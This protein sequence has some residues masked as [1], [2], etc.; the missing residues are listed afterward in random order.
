MTA[1]GYVIAV[2]R[3]RRPVRPGG[4]HRAADRSRP[5]GRPPRRH[6]PHRAAALVV[7]VRR[8]APVEPGRRAG[9]E[10]AGPRAAARRVAPPRRGGG[11]RR[12][13][14]SP[15]WSAGAGWRQAW[16]PPSWSSPWWSRSSG[17]APPPRARSGA[18]RS[19]RA[20]VPRGPAR[21]TP[22]S[23]RCSSATSRPASSS[24]RPSTSSC[25]PRTS[26]TSTSW[27]RSDEG[28]ELADLARSARHDARRRRRR[29]RRCRP[30]HQLLGRLRT[31]T[32]RSSIATTRSTVCRSASTSRCAWLL[33]P[34]GGANLTSRDARD[35]RATRAALDPGRRPQRGHLVGD[36]LRRP[37]P[38]RRRGRRRA[39]AQPDE[40]IVV[41]RHAGAD[42]A[43][44]GVA[45]AGDRE[46]PVA[47]PGG[48]HRLLGDHR[49][50]R[51]GRAAHRG[52]RAGG[53]AR[54]GRAALGHDAVHAARLRA[55][56]GRGAGQ[57]GARVAR[58]PGAARSLRTPRGRRPQRRRAHGRSRRRCARRR[59]A[60]RQT[61]SDERDGAVVDEGDAHVGP[62]APG[63]HLSP[64]AS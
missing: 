61:S 7:A 62:E 11:R 5:L 45:D 63:R 9:G 35:R 47:A 25:G 20:A 42:P 13:R 59:T 28:A 19:C 6:R 54:H 40:R 55:G 21:G 17:P 50:R 33:E 31:P 41:H 8:R 36:L 48:A 3:L 52:V 64:E 2:G 22:T 34:F 38:R 37:R 49:A 44:G 26:S 27:R 32:A 16:R 29:G 53:A 12:R 46:R 57:P 15:R 18:W 51:H 30:L 60:P 23:A 56:S 1:P 58:S 39:G 10:P 24:S 43:G 4:D 14:P